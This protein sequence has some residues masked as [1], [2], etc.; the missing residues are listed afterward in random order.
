MC[1]CEACEAVRNRTSTV[2]ALMCTCG[3][4]LADRCSNMYDQ[5]DGLRRSLAVQIDAV[6][7]SV[8][9]QVENASHHSHEHGH[10]DIV[11]FLLVSL[12]LSI[13]CFYLLLS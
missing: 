5:I 4:C 12:A 3:V 2:H 7:H 11:L 8:R 9:V 13:L 6:R 10:V 1:K